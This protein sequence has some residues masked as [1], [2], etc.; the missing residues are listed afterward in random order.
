MDGTILNTIKDLTIATNHA[1][2][3]YGLPEIT[4]EEEKNC[5]GNGL[6]M[7]A[8]RAAPEGC[9][10]KL[11]K[12]VYEELASYYKDH[13]EENTGPYE[14]IVEVI[15]EL[16][17]RGILTAVVSNKA[18]YA[19]QRLVEK[20]FDDCFL[21]ALGETEGLALKPAPDMV[22]EILKRLHVETKDAVYVGD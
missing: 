14:G 5:V 18:D 1:L 11:V 9:E 4:E 10:D 13:C 21:L 2:S 16:K 17:D 8:K 22:L 19:V 6:Y 20:Y 3:M 15:K 7:T 12:K